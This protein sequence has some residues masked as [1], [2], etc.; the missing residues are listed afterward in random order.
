MG[1]DSL[2]ANTTGTSNTAL[3]YQALDANTT[4]NHGTA[5]GY[6]ALSANTTARRKHSSRLSS[7]FNVTRQGLDGVAVG[8]FALKSANTTGLHNVA[9]G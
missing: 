4:G 8:K 9:V 6:Q 1:H 7:L 3:G 2:K 5:V